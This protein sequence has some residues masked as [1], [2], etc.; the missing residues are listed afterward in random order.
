M[1]L[2]SIRNIFHRFVTSDNEDLRTIA[3]Q[4]LQ[5]T[6]DNLSIESRFIPEITEGDKDVSPVLLAGKWSNLNINAKQL[7]KE[8]WRES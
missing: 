8:A 4:V 7:R 3:Q 1:K 5:K 2:N 6:D